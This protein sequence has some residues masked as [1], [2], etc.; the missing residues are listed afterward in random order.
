MDSD[1]AADC[2]VCCSSAYHSLIDEIR[3]GQSSLLARAEWFWEGY[4]DT[5]SAIREML[6]TSGIR[7]SLAG[8]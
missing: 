5:L 7:G 3:C 1:G 4:L 8:R 2:M 6:A